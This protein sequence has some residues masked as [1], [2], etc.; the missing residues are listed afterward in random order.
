MRLCSLLL[1]CLAA[2]WSST[3]VISHAH[4]WN[5]L[6]LTHHW[7]NT[8]CRVEHCHSNLSYWTL[9]GLWPDKGMNCNS[10]WHFNASQIEDLLPDMKQSWPDL[11]H[12]STTKFWK[13]EW[14]KHG[15]CAAEASS[16]DSQHKYF[17]KGL[18]LYHKVDLHSILNKFGITPS[19]TYYSI[20]QIEG[21][22]ENFYG[23]KP[24]IQCAHS[25]KNVDV[26][27]LG[28][29]EICFDPDFTLLDCEKQFS[30]ENASKVNW[31]NATAVDKAS[32][33]SVCDRDAPVY[34][35]PDP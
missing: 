6:I 15:T 1:L 24:K 3:F 33:F 20:S 11:L 21:V 30:T 4:M 10:S 8:F 29:I 9:H 7:P 17:S 18:E 19:E 27:L 5:K 28:Q 13:Y 31:D 32:E 2:T 16:L 23:V 34:Y 22:I 26:Q 12:P 25:S 14:Y 35:P